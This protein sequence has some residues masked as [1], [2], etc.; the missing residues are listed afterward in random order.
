MEFEDMSDIPTEILEDR[1][2]DIF[3]IIPRHL[4]ILKTHIKFIFT[5]VRY[6]DKSNVFHC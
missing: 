5:N 4:L 3:L 1:N 2:E 6:V